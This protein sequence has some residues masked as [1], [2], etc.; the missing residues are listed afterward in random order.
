[1]EQIPGKRFAG[2]P[3]RRAGG[4]LLA[5]GLACAL[6]VASLGNASYAQTQASS[7]PAR[8]AIR[9]NKP[10]IS[11]VSPPAAAPVLPPAPVPAAIEPP[12]PKHLTPEQL[13]PQPPN[14][15]W[16]GK[17]LTIDADNSTLSDVLVAVRVRTGASI[18]MPDTAVGERVFVHL[19]PAPV[20]D[21]ISSL[22]YGT[23]FDY[24]IQS[25]DTDD[26]ALRSVVLTQRGKGGDD[27][28]GGV[29]ATDLPKGVRMMKGWAA[30][31]KRD[32]EVAHSNAADSD[33]SPSAPA[34]SSPADTSSANAAN[35]ASTDADPNS[36]PPSEAADAGSVAGTMGSSQASARPLDST[37]GQSTAGSGSLPL[38]INDMQ[39]LFEQ[40]RQ[41]QAQQNQA[42]GVVPQS[43]SH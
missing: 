10:A 8:N 28:A 13:P 17:Q 27:T 30:P 11:A 16:D 20:R 3:L 43:S 33:A 41:I 39:R 23:D 22:L 38:G 14:V 25:S 29:V 18:D 7:S 31:G 36:T 15:S 42:A 37:A 2:Q 12:Q 34:E 4:N 19:G 40:R 32:F 26:D 9:K 5:S 6:A 35:P 24:V 21:V 1:V